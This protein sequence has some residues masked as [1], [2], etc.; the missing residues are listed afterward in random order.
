MEMAA[1][2]KM[3]GGR[4]DAHRIRL[5]GAFASTIT[6]Y[7]IAARIRFTRP[8]SRSDAPGKSS[9]LAAR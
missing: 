6:A 7:A 9:M 3:P 8:L 5:G 1:E 2:V 4:R